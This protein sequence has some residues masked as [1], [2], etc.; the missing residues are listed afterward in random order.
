LL[1]GEKVESYFVDLTL[2]RIDKRLTLEHQMAPRQIAVD[3]SLAGTIHRLL[4]QSTHAKQPFAKI[5]QSLLKAG[6]HYPN[7]P[8]M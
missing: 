2:G 3:V 1:H 7:L 4:R 6:T 8:V 5:V